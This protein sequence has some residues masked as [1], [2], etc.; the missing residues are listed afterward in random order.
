MK[1]TATVSG[2]FA[3]LTETY[4]VDTLKNP[5]EGTRALE[6]AIEKIGF[7]QTETE[8]QK[9]FIGAD[10]MRWSITVRD[11]GREH[12]VSFVEDGSPAS[13]DWQDLVSQI[14]SLQ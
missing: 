13:L 11:G 4:Q 14:K 7:F 10:M 9:E 12:T 8:W 5:S 2:G 1:I 3:G 6:E